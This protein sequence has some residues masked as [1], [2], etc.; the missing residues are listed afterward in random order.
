MQGRVVG[1]AEIVAKP[2]D[3]GG[4]GFAGHHV[5]NAEGACWV[6]AVI[7][8]WCVSTDPELSSFRVRSTRIAR[9]DGKAALE[10]AM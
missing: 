7:P 6:R 2:D 5:L 10:A 1:E 4:S 3:V 9:N 8:G